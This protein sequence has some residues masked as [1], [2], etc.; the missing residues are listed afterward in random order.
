MRL[1][2]VLHH[3]NYILCKIFGIFG[4]ICKINWEMR[5]NALIFS[6]VNYFASNFD[7]KQMHFI[8]SNITALWNQ[9]LFATLNEDVY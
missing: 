3:Q 1:H 9:Q 6:F 2:F 8:F 7:N 5:K 4:K